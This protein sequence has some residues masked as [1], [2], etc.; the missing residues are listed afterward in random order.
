MTIRENT[1]KY[2]RE[3]GW[4]E[5]RKIDITEIVKYLEGYGYEVFEPVKSFLEE[6]GM[7]TIRIPDDCEFSNYKYNEHHTNV[8][9]AVNRP[10]LYMG[11]EQIEKYAGE[12]L[13]PVGMVYNENLWLY[14]SESG[15]LCCDT[16]MF[17]NNFMEGW[18][19]LI[20]RTK[21]KPFMLEK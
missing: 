19:C 11:Y 14:V 17:G 3:A 2:L 15:R 8:M 7:L 18:D 9:E 21:S 12:R 6:F 13:I 20:S 10:Y 16:V 1:L 5:G 4:Y